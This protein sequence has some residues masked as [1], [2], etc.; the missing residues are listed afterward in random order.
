LRFRNIH[1]HVVSLLKQAA[2]LALPTRGK[3][4]TIE[5]LEIPA[6]VADRC[7]HYA[8]RL[9][10]VRK[11]SCSGV[12]LKSIANTSPVLR[13]SIQSVRRAPYKPR[14]APVFIQPVFERGGAYPMIRSQC[15]T[16]VALMVRSCL[17]MHEESDRAN[18]PTPSIKS[19]FRR[20][21]L[22]MHGRK[23]HHLNQNDPRKRS[24]ALMHCSGSS[25]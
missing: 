20:R 23:P 13:E 7:Q 22:T 14:F 16:F 15:L 9:S 25:T 5:P 19:G 12:N 4:L 8:T 6:G 21:Q 17:R 2:T 24:N 3:D 10:I 1:S 18:Q 11:A